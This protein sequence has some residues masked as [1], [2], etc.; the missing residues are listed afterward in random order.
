VAGKLTNISTR[1][2]VGTENNV[3]IGGVIVGAGS[4]GGSRVVVRAIGP[5]LGGVVQGELADPILLLYNA[6]GTA[7][8][9]NDNWKINDLTYAWQEAEVRASGLPPANERESAIV[10]SLAPGNYTALSWK[11][12]TLPASP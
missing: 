10:T 2:F 9:S 12:T 4:G 11:K 3:M 7:L 6:N 8:A 5:S 1:G